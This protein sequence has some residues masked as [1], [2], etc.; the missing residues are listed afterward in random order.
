MPAFPVTTLGQPKVISSKPLEG[1]DSKFVELLELT[2][3]AAN[4]TERRWEAVN[5]K[6]RGPGVAAD[7]VDIFARIH[8]PTKEP[9]TIIVLQFRPAADAISVEFPAGLI[10][11]GETPA[12]AALRELQEETGFGSTNG[13][14]TKVEELSE[15]CA[16]SPGMSTETT[17]FATVEIILPPGT[18]EFPTPK[19]KLDE[20]EFIE[21]RLVPLSTLYETLV[22]YQKLGYK[23]DT[24]L[25]HFA[26]GLKLAKQLKQ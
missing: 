18:E 16:D 12:E 3:V 8:H 23:L 6:T 9:H 1:T 11:E 2:Y 20:G 17:I 21:I 15:P 10:D 19:Q 25:H 24:R 22:E 5:R 26:Y 7:A 14:K 13:M 4:G